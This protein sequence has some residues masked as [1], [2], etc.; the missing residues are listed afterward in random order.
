MSEKEKSPAVQMRSAI[1]C[2]IYAGRAD[3]S[4][5]GF[6]HKSFAGN[7]IVSIGA[8]RAVWTKINMHDSKRQNDGRNSNQEDA[9]Q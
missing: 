8:G 7:A 5:S 4:A 6:Q 3:E 9:L 2:L 1:Y